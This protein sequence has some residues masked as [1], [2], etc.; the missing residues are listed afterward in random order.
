M[1][2]EGFMFLFLLVGNIHV[3][4]S[5]IAHSVNFN[6]ERL[7]G[8]PTSYVGVNNSASIVNTIELAHLS[9]NSIFS[10]HIYQGTLSFPLSLLFIFTK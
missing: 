3:L 1:I 4:P 8:P 7:F 2:R 10:S 9:S 5:S 6:F